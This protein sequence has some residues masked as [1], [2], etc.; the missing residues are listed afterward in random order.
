M[1][2][3]K[4]PSNRGFAAAVNQ[5]ISAAT[6]AYVLLLNDD[7]VLGPGY[8]RALVAVLQL[9]PTR[10]SA[11][12]RLLRPTSP[13]GSVAVDSTGHVMYRCV[14]ARNRDQGELDRGVA[15]D[16][17]EVFGVSA[18]ASLY[19]RSM[20]DDVAVEGE[21]FDES[22][23]SYLEDVDFDW[24][25]RIRGWSSWYES[26]A[27]A[28]HERGPSR[29]RLPSRVQRGILRNRLL[30]IV[31]NDA[32]GGR[33][34]RR[35]AISAFTLAKLGQL[36]VS[37]PAAVLGLWDFLRFRPA[38]RRKR[39]LIQSRRLVPPELLEAWFVPLYGPPASYV[40]R[41]RR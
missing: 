34:G 27:I 33:W 31:K 38:A 30:M 6:G 24:R 20:L 1:A 12:G 35:P 2:L 3:T 16:S 36:L 5:G 9:D 8:V 10:G 7:V 18:A 19:R 26:Q 21:V 11:T 32:G 37:Q 15:R 4:N 29:A 22:F 41:L 28:V 40:R 17:G 39:R 13:D 14:W 25:A 23:G